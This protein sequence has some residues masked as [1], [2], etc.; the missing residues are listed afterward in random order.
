M[1][2]AYHMCYSKIVELY[3]HLFTHKKGSLCTLLYLYL[4][5]FL[6]LANKKKLYI[7]THKDKILDFQQ[8][9]VSAIFPWLSWEIMSL[10]WFVTK[11]VGICMYVL[12][13][14]T[15][16]VFDLCLLMALFWSKLNSLCQS[17]SVHAIFNEK[18][19]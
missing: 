1:S 16:A 7:Y 3:N 9:V 5:H 13:K 12:L 11:E 18:Q 17:K 8:M 14:L 15:S 10:I 19:H 2:S 4:C 6:L